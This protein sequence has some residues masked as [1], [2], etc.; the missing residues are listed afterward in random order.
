MPDVT[1][2]TVGELHEAFASRRLSPVELLE[3]I[4]E[5][6]DRCNAFVTV[7]HDRAMDT[8]REAERLLMDSGPDAL[9]DRPLLGI[10]ISVKDLIP[11]RGL[12][13]TRGS[14]L[15]RD[16]IPDFDAPAVERLRAAGAVIL[17]KTS[18]SEFG[19][20]AASR[21]R[22]TG[23][24]PNPW[25]GERTAGGSSCGAA[26]AVATGLGVGA[27]GTD[28][29]GSVRIPAAFCGVVGFKPSFGRIPYHPPSEELLSHLGPLTRGV[30]DAALLVEVMAGPDRRDLFSLDSVWRGQDVRT[31]APPLRVGWID[32]LGEPA[33][34]PEILRVARSAVRALAEAGHA[35]REIR[36]PFE[37]PYP[38]LVTIL[39][40]AEAAAHASVPAGD[41]ALIDPGRLPIIEYGRRLRAVDLMAA[42]RA[43]TR[44]WEQVRGWLD[45]FDLLAMPTVPV[46]PFLATE[47]EPDLR[48]DKGEP[49]W[50]GWSPTTYCFN[51]TGQ[52]AISL[53]AGFTSEGLPVGVQLVAGWRADHTV[54]RAALDL[55]RVRPWRHTYLHLRTSPA[56]E[57]SGSS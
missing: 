31:G 3:R 24:T 50:L 57:R 49:S 16:W 54:L 18:T 55:E 35:V 32:G 11:T 5:L 56:H 25:D 29:A 52:P 26:V 22:V 8:A 36:P 4:F 7:D 41:E 17:G 28:G 53:P 30:A 46:K 23:V 2:W 6:P 13:T 38:A 47:D 42:Q 43:R 20:S 37:D 51:L 48:L 19:W 44:L 9:G 12:R 45:G 21:N 40:S 34:D 10:P 15:H 27:T 1:S 14:L 33:P 39:A